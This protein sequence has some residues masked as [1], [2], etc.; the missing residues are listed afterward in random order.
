MWLFRYQE[1]QRLRQGHLQWMPIQSVICSTAAGQFDATFGFLG[2]AR[3]SGGP[4]SR[5]R[6]V[7]PDAT[8]IKSS[9][10]LAEKDLR[11]NDKKI[12]RSE[13]EVV[14][15]RHILSG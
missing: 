1:I 12:S 5:F 8:A 14:Y 11:T 9:C 6:Q 10:V 13:M 3:K 15:L 4:R 7:R 2:E